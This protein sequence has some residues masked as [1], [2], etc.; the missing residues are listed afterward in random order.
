MCSTLTYD[1][2]SMPTC[3]GVYICA[4][5]RIYTHR[6][7]EQ[8]MSTLLCLQDPSRSENHFALGC[9]KVLKPGTGAG[10]TQ[11]QPWVLWGR[12]GPTSTVRICAGVKRFSLCEPRGPDSKSFPLALPPRSLL[13][14]PVVCTAKVSCTALNSWGPRIRT[15]IE[16]HDS[17]MNYTPHSFVRL[18][19]ESKVS[20]TR[21][22]D[23]KQSQ[24]PH[25]GQF[26]VRGSTTGAV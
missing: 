23:S 26:R 10:R 3:I 19:E 4:Y 25:L 7:Q 8:G 2:L 6:Q 21:Q 9:Y 16:P 20:N 13:H 22:K 5:T 11:S 24:T 1:N 18:V 12:A 14:E 15:P 17:K